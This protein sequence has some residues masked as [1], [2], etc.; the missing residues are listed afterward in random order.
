MLWG[1]TEKTVLNICWLYLQL[2]LWRLFLSNSVILHWAALVLNVLY[3]VQKGHTLKGAESSSSSGRTSLSPQL[4]PLVTRC[5]IRQTV[6][7]AT[8]PSVVCLQSRQPKPKFWQGS[9]LSE[10]WCPLG[11]RRKGT[12]ICYEVSQRC[13]WAH[14]PATA[15]PFTS[16]IFS[17]L[18]FIRG[19]TCTELSEQNRAHASD[20]CSVQL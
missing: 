16:N 1:C 18:S 19:V 5:V 8:P 3:H 7:D 9:C 14:G 12:S 6:T 10:S 11:E 20:C 4:Q 13:W 17:N 2:P 15:S